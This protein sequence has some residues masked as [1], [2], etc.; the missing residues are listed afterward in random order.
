MVIDWH[1]LLIGLAIAAAYEY[2]NRRKRPR[3]QIL[4]PDIDQWISI[5]DGDL[6]IARREDCLL[7]LIIVTNG[8]KVKTIFDFDFNQEGKAIYS[9]YSPEDGLVTHWRPMPLP[10]KVRK[11]K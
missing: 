4:E 11:G 9:K 8:R 2:G 10:P 3:V 1:L 5:E 6:N 7:D